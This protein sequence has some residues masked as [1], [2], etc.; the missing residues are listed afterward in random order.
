MYEISVQWY[1]SD[2]LISGQTN[3]TTD[4]TGIKRVIKV[5]LLQLVTCWIY[6]QNSSLA[7]GDL[8]NILNISI[9]FRYIFLCTVSDGNSFCV[10]QLTISKRRTRQVFISCRLGKEQI[11]S[12]IKTDRHMIQRCFCARY[13]YKFQYQ[14]QNVMLLVIMLRILFFLHQQHSDLFYTQ[15]ILSCEPARQII[16]SDWLSTTCTKTDDPNLAH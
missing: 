3:S 8:E 13:A 1:I 5:S 6:S 15:C 2:P 10:H 14:L 12:Y 11:L 16:F 7:G 9:V 4:Y